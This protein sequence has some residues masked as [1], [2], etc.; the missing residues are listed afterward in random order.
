MRLSITLFSILTVYS[1]STS[2]KPSISLS[3]VVHSSIDGIDTLSVSTSVKN[4]GGETAKL[5]KAP[6]AVL[7]TIPTST[8]SFRGENGPPEFAEITVS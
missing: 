6:R 8:F 1:K 4:I 3:I 7:S 2:A 5:L